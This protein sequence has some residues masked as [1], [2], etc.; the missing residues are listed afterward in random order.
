VTA[1]LDG[2]AIESGE[3]QFRRFRCELFAFAV[4]LPLFVFV[5]LLD[6]RIPASFAGRV[7]VAPGEALVW[8][9]VACTSKRRTPDSMAAASVPNFAIL[10][11][12]DLVRVRSMKPGTAS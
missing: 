12:V 7:A 11:F 3:V 4:D 6:G 1:R 9:L 8:A 10:I 2:A 5:H